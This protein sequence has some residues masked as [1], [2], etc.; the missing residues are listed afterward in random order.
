MQNNERGAAD[1]ARAS[2]TPAAWG[3][4]GSGPAPRRKRA[5]R[6]RTTSAR[7]QFWRATQAD[8]RAE[9][10]RSTSRFCSARR[11]RQVSARSTAMQER[12][13]SQL[14]A[15][16]RSAGQRNVRNLVPM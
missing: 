8:P 7:R 16:E 5:R 9:S 2:I 6:R 11:Q 3:R 13:T 14:H 12:R 1:R 4:P 10:R 15:Q